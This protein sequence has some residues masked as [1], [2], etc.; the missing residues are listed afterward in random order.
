MAI[1]D[2]DL[3]LAEQLLGRGIALSEV[4]GILNVTESALGSLAAKAKAEVALRSGYEDATG[5]QSLKQF[6][7]TFLEEWPGNPLGLSGERPWLSISAIARRQGWKKGDF[8]SPTAASSGRPRVDNSELRLGAAA[9]TAVAMARSNPRLNLRLSIIQAAAQH[10][11]TDLNG[12]M[13]HLRSKAPDLW[14]GRSKG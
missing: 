1:S 2:I 10:G 4:A 7:G 12:M 6:S 9:D 3:L 5:E 11:V 13:P 14:K 8:V